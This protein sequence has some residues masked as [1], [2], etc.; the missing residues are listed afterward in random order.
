MNI[1]LGQPLEIRG[2]TVTMRVRLG[3]ARTFLEFRDGAIKAKEGAELVEGS[4]P[5]EV[6][7]EV[8]FDEN[9]VVKNSFKTT[10][11]LK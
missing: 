1:E 9:T 8:Q 6:L 10:I 2:K 5:I 3:A 7:L 11:K 4:F